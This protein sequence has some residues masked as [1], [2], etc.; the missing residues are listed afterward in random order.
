MQQENKL[1]KNFII[2]TFVTLYVMVSVISTIH[3]IDFFKLSNPTWLAITLA[4]AFEVGSAA[5][6]ASII[7]LKKMNKGIVWALFFILTA[8][9]AMGNAYFAYTHL[10]NYQSWVE[11][12]GLIDYEPIF[13][14]RVLSIVSGAIL[15]L[16]ALGFIKSLVDYIKPETE[17]EKG[18]DVIIDDG[19]ISEDIKKVREDNL[20]EEAKRVWEKV[21]ELREEGKLPE[22]Y[23]IEKEPTDEEEQ[24]QSPFTYDEE[25]LK[26]FNEWDV[27]LEDGLS[28]DYIIEEK[29][30]EEDS[31]IDIQIVK[32]DEVTE[33]PVQEEK[34]K[35]DG[36]FGLNFE[37]ENV[38]TEDQENYPVYDK[39]NDDKN[40]IL[41]NIIV[42]TKNGDQ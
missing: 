38:V 9:Q 25:T 5:S 16:V 6:L 2:G 14:K 26:E 19:G 41:E 37:E 31:L 15:P 18:I 22:T 27:T 7:A 1:T 17:E 12:F 33:E 13:Q 24:A 20:N 8:M 39:T 30:T 21:H 29:Q 36:I 42:Y 32:D 40:K 28:E 10:T 11:L 23:E 34:P 35:S 3:V 4:L